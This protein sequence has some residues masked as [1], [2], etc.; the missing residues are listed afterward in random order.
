MRPIFQT[1]FTLGGIVGGTVGG[2]VGDRW[3]R[4]RAVQIGCTVNILVV[5]G[6]ILIP[7]YP[8]VLILRL[9]A[10]C[11]VMGMLVPAWSLVLESTPA[12]LRSRVGMLLGL[13][14]S[15]STISMAALGYFIRAWKYLLLACTSPIL[16]LLPLSFI[17]DES[18]RWLLQRGRIDD[19]T[20][21]LRKAVKLHDAHL[22]VPLTITV[23]K[24]AQA[25]NRESHGPVGE[26]SALTPIV[27]A[28]RQVWSYLRSPAMRI[29]ILVTPIIWFLQSCLYLGVVINAN[30]FTSTDPFLYLALSGIMEGSAILALTPLTTRIGR[31]VIV[32]AGLTLGGFFLLLELLVPIS[33]Y[34]AKWVLVM[35][36]FLL[37]AGSYQ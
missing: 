13:P 30:N 3:G 37:V 22:P 35:M 17:A 23:E 25:I 26:V 20:R 34:W 16:I 28:L 10:G 14:F 4:G 27:E 21:I 12:R 9:V 11:T 15:A 32:W 2:Y 33:Y 1:L 7:L 31:R 19:A 24:L 8:I 36:G 18:P 6:I 29:I 5:A